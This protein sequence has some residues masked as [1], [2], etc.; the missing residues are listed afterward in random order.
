[1]GWSESDKTNLAD[2]KARPRQEVTFTI[3]CSGNH[4]LPFFNGGIGNARWAGT[5][6]AP[7]L[8][9]AGVLDSGVEA[10]FWCADEG[11]IERPDKIKFK[12]NF[13]RSMSVADAMD[14]NNIL[15]YEMN[16]VPLPPD[17]GFP[18]RLIARAG[19]ASR[20]RNGSSAS[21]CALSAS[22]PGSW[23]AIMLPCAK[24]TTMA[25]PCGWRPRWGRHGFRVG[26]G[27]GHPHRKRLSD[28]WRRLGRANRQGRG[29]DRRRAVDAGDHRS[30]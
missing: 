4:G 26:T 29:E 23:D 18:L 19:T 6:L 3:E 9:E 7:I 25:R 30:Q 8:K 14:P 27:P 2:I 28:R 11:E 1:M 13:A 10:V 15:C 20:M 24:K 22:R 16:G 5:P 12:Q 21:T 17:N